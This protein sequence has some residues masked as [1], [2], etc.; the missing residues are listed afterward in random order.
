[1]KISTETQQ[2][3]KNFTLINPGIVLRPG[4]TLNQRKESVIAEANV[5]ETF[6]KEVGIYNLGQLLQVI[7]LYTDPDLTFAEDALYIAET[8]GSAVTKYTYAPPEL[9]SGG[10]QPKK[11]KA[12]PADVIE[13]TISEEQWAKLQKAISVLGSQEVKV[14]SDG[15]T[16]SIGTTDHK[17]PHGS[18][19]SLVLS[20]D[21]HGISCNSVYSRDDLQLLKG[22]YSGTVTPLF[23][24]FKN[25]SGLD[26]T[27]WIA[28]EPTISTFGS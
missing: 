17:N 28:I 13:F 7:G 16:I 18:S 21:A 19:F 5:V 20:G 9:V 6:P 11:K 10:S 4:N 2:I 1:M 8:D 27:Y 15:K 25:T 14:T 23:T 26:L 12:I 3:L 24:V 22:S